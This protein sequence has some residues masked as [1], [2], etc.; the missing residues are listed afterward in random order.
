MENGE[1]RGCHSG[2]PHNQHTS[3]IDGQTDR[4]RVMANT[5]LCTAQRRALKMNVKLVFVAEHWVLLVR[6]SGIYCL[7][8]CVTNLLDAINF[9]VT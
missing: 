3:V 7:N 6:N 8:I 1:L 4:Y 5:A 2:R 9:D